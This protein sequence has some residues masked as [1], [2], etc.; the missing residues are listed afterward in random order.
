MQSTFS[1]PAVSTPGWTP[2]MQLQPVVQPTQTVHPAQV[3]PVMQ[4]S[5]A[6]VMVVH[7]PNTMHYQVQMNQAGWSN[8]QLNTAQMTMAYGMWKSDNKV[9]CESDWQRLQQE[10]ALRQQQYQML[11]TEYQAALSQIETLKVKLSELEK[12]LKIDQ[13]KH[14]ELNNKYIFAIQS[15]QNKYQILNNMHIATTNQLR[16]ERCKYDAMSIELQESANNLENERR[17][18]GVLNAMYAETKKN[19]LSVRQKQE[20]QVNENDKKNKSVNDQSSRNVECQIFSKERLENLH[21]GERSRHEHGTEDFVGTIAG[22]NNPSQTSGVIPSSER[23]N[24]LVIPPPGFESCNRV[25]RN[26]GSLVE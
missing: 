13:W 23:G 14:Q 11:Q 21:S 26:D 17:K 9:P 12:N 16:A 5:Q 10:G 3:H 24:H 15:E 8:Q 20:K 7:P 18:Y 19:L 25:P 6:Q 1:I 22:T 2:A 4:P